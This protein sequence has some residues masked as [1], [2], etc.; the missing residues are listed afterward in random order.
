MGKACVWT[1]LGAVIIG[2]CATGSDDAA[3][4]AGGEPPIAVVD[5]SRDHDSMDI[6]SSGGRATDDA[7]IVDASIEDASSAVHEDATIP[8]GAELADSAIDSAVD[9]ESQ[10]VNLAPLGDGYTWQSMTS[11]SADTGKLAAAAVN[12]DSLATQANIDNASGDNVNAWQ[13]AG[14]VFASAHTI[15]LVRFVQGTTGSSSGDGW[16]EAN[17]VLQFSMD[18]STWHDAGWSVAPAYA[19]SSAVS[20]KMYTMSGAPAAGV[21]G[22]RV[23]GQ[24]N[25]VGNSWWAAV[26]EVITLGH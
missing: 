14:T 12:D 9:G 21:R 18:G 5:A 8:D 22:V 24:V 7:S 20:G 6:D 19:Y 13:A 1:V 4:D 10:D 3:V 16:F 11:S 15:T 25:T 23:A 26:T 2:G 17:L